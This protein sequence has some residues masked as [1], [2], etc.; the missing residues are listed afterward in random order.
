MALIDFDIDDIQIVN[1][2]IEHGTGIYDVIRLAFMASTEEPCDECFQTPDITQHIERFP[3]GQFV[4]LHHQT[5]VGMAATLRTN[6]SPDQPPLRW[7]EAIGDKGI[8][9]HDPT[10]E[11]LYGVEM[12]VHPDYHHKGIGTRLY[13]ARFELVKQLNLKGWY[14]AGML[15]GYHRF[16]QQMMVREYAEK[17]IGRE[18]VDPTVTMQLNRGFTA[19]AII[20]NYIDEPAAGDAAILIVWINPDYIS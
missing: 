12:A 1:T 7:I 17:V 16:Q 11:W 19:K 2:Q 9:K 14:A 5:V 13:K 3:E 20:E 4:A 10:G 6:Y 15:M 8:S 18:I